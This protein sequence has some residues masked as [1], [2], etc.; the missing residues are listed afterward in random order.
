MSFTIMHRGGEMEEGD[1]LMI[2]RLLE[3]LDGPR[4]DEHPDVSVCDDESAWS[5][6]AFQ[7]GSLIFENLDSSEFAP[8]HIVNVPRS[9]MT[10]AMVLL[11]RGRLDELELMN[12]E[13]GYQS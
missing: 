7:G 10:R 8:R 6:S 4:D 2:P 1:E 9:E 3:E 11:A 13:P 5:I 12:W